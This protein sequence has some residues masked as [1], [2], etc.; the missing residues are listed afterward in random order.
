MSQQTPE[1]NQTHSEPVIAT[2][3]PASP[4]VYERKVSSPYGDEKKHHSSSSITKPL[5]VTDARAL[6]AKEEADIEATRERRV[7]IW[8]KIRPFILTGLALLILGWWISATVLPATRP[9][10][11]VAYPNRSRIDFDILR[12]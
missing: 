1:L 6:D 10:W 2:A 4:L 9:R 3:T 7:G 8:R 5:G 11:Y 12:Y